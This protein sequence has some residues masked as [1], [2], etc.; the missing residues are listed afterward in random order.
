MG[1]RQRRKQRGIDD[2]VDGRGGADAQSQGCDDR[3][4]QAAVFAQHAHT[5]TKILEQSSHGTSCLPAGS[6]SRRGSEHFPCQKGR[7]I[8]RGKADF[9][10]RCRRRAL[11]CL[12]SIVKPCAIPD[13]E[14]S[15]ICRALSHA[16]AS[17]CL[18]SH[19]MFKASSVKTA[20]GCNTRILH[21]REAAGVT[22]LALIPPQLLRES[23]CLCLHSLY[24]TEH[25][26]NAGTRHCGCFGIRIF[27]DGSGRLASVWPRSGGSPAFAAHPNQHHQCEPLAARLDVSHRGEGAILRSDAYLR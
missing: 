25:A 1:K 17:P 6:D 9:L 24:E 14:S 21:P 27:T 4:G 20:Y 7:E 26:H 8:R 16:V 2:G 15:P 13:N 10:A 12:F 19:L 22:G 11:D 23:A 5:I 18:L 3:K